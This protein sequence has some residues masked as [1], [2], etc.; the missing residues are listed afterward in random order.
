MLHGSGHPHGG[1]KVGHFSSV[2]SDSL[3]PQGL[4]HVRLPCPSLMPRAYSNSCPSSR[5][6]HPTISY[7]VVPF[8]SCLQS[9][10][11]SETIPRCHFFTS[12]SQS[13]G[14]SVSNK[15]SGLISY[16]MDWLDLLALQGT[17]K[18]SPTPQFKSINSLVL[19]FLY[20]PTLTSINDYRKTI[21][22]TR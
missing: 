3:W 5:W 10:P 22:L 19:S 9:F 13:I 4:Q 16:R 6:C 12:G 11:A 2:V 20:G 1:L 8:S 21:A 17:L 18:F 7:S 15:Y 14:V